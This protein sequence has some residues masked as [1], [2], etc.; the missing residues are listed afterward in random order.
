MGIADLR[1]LYTI[2]KDT[3]NDT[4]EYASLTQ[5]EQLYINKF[6]HFGFIESNGAITL[7]G[8]DVVNNFVN[9]AIKYFNGITYNEYTVITLNTDTTRNKAGKYIARFLKATKM[10]SWSAFKNG[11][12]AYMTNGEAI[13]VGEILKHSNIVQ[14]DQKSC[15]TLLKNLIK[16]VSV[17]N[18]TEVKPVMFHKDLFTDRAIF[19][20]VDGT[21][22]NALPIQAHYIEFLWHRLSTNIQFF[23][24][25]DKTALFV[26]TPVVS[27]RRN[28]LIEK[29]IGGF[30][31]P[32]K[33]V[34]FKKPCTDIVDID[35]N[36]IK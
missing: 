4:R 2:Y 36:T 32:M 15:C 20:F 3:N 14:A 11:D 6:R 1:Y 31:M 16:E 23:A 10:T 34:P 8:R 12:V 33:I 27:R 22:D 18:W 5:E 35:E 13:L 21:G 9:N 25:D 24:R 30:I 7:K 19:W 17:G 26:K 28:L 29:G